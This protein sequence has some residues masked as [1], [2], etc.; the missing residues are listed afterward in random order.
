MNAAE[1]DTPHSKYNQWA[2]DAKFWRGIVSGKGLDDLIVSYKMRESE[3]QKEQRIRLTE[4]PTPEAANRTLSHYSRLQSTDKRGVK[5]TYKK[6]GEAKAVLT[7][8]LNKFSGGRSLEDFLFETFAPQVAT[9]PHSFLL[10]LFDGPRDSRGDFIEKPYPRPEII[11]TEQ[12]WNLKA[13]NGVYEWLLRRVNHTGKAK[14]ITEEYVKNGYGSP[15]LMSSNEGKDITWIEY[16]LYFAGYTQTLTQIT[17]ANPVT[18]LNKNQEI[19]EVM[20]KEKKPVQW[21]LTTFTTQQTRPPFIQ[22][23]FDRD[24]IDR[25]SFLSVLHPAK[26]EFKNL[27]NRASEYALT[28]A[29]HTFLQKYQYV[30]DCK[31]TAPGQGKC[32]HGTMSATNETCPKCKGSGRDIVATVQDVVTIKYPE[33]GERLMPLSNMIYYPTLPFEIVNHLKMEVDEKPDKI[34]RA[35]WGCCL[36]KTPT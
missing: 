1:Q 13:V 33:D 20:N 18:V 30:D 9:D 3:E 27:I 7:E 12:V 28:L 22:Y 5:I 23:G 10:V 24:P 6:E 25:D 26:S 19:V 34:E 2:D 16:T 8:R 35:M 14:A 15:V 17:E 29:L 36:V 21:L 4:P 31:F 32:S 11:P